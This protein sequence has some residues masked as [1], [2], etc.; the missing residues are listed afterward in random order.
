MSGITLEKVTGRVDL[1]KGHQGVLIEKTPVITA[2]VSWRSGTDYDVYA[3]VMLKDGRQI[4]VAT[5]GAQGVKPLAD[6]KGAVRHLG[7]VR[8]G[9]GGGQQTETLEIRLTDEIHAV[10]P[11]AYSAQSNGTGS[12]RRYVVSLLIDNG[13]GTQVGISASNANDDDKVY[14]CVPGIIR[15]TSDGVLIKPLELYSKRGSERRPRLELRQADGLVGVF[16][17]GGPVNLFK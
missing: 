13:A 3:L 15:N 14:T 8:R 9:S 16:M 5:F 12:F 6:Y 10:V 7:D 4:D 1:V 2:S 17:D 11:V